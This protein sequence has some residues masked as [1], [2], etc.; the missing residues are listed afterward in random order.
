MNWSVG[1]DKASSQPLRVVN[2]LEHQ[3]EVPLMALTRNS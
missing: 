3:V 2:Q 1:I